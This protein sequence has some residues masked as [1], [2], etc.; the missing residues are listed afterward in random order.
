MD[1]STLHSFLSE[2]S[3]SA[4]LGELERLKLRYSILEASEPRLVG[5][6]FTDIPSLRIARDIKEEAYEK[7]REI[8]LHELYFSSFAKNNPRC[9]R[10]PRQ[11]SSPAEMAYELFCLAKDS[12][13][14][15]FLVVYG[16]PSTGR[17]GF[18]V[19]KELS[20]RQVPILALDLCEHAYFCDYGFEREEYLRNASAH[21]DL[22]RV[23][24]FIASVR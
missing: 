10:L 8:E 16:E 24:E 6:C 1:V 17:V 11:F 4:H 2:D 23:S 19:S 21:L 15:D 5:V 3:V 9:E 13:G 22:S 12:R 20:R 14:V 7:R 18:S